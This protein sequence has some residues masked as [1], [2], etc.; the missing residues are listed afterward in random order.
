MSD[1]LAS[2]EQLQTLLNRTFDE[3]QTAQTELLLG[4]ASASIRS[5]AG[6]TLSLVEDDEAVLAGTWDYD[7]ELPEWPVVA[8][9]SVA[10]NDVAVSDGN[11]HWNNRELLR[12]ARVLDE[13]SGAGFAQA[14]PG[15]RFGYPG[16]WG[17]PGS[18]VTVVYTHG[19]ETIP[20]DL[21][22]ICLNAVARNLLTPAG[23]RS[24]SIGSFSVSY[25][26]D[27]ATV[28]LTDSEVRII[29][30]RYRH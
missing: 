16:H 23:V 13:L 5:E 24:E 14:G 8:V 18:S 20:D 12:R 19:Y 30:S 10:L 21:A 7:L 2:V 9:A 4:L 25:F 17:G 15:A 1:P 26:A 6:Q 3:G 28:D 22:A 27:S 11:F 29:R